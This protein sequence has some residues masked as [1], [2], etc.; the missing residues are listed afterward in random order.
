MARR[1][2]ERAERQTLQEGGRGY[3]PAGLPCSVDTK[4]G[5]V[6]AQALRLRLA[7][8]PVEDAKSVIRDRYYCDRRSHPYSCG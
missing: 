6:V 5:R 2:K 4:T 7:C 8:V 3:A 1:N